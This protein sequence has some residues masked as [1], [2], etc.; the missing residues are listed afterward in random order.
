MSNLS[1]Q[2]EDS[3]RIHFIPSVILLT[4]HLPTPLLSSSGFLYCH[5]PVFYFQSSSDFL[6]CHPP[7]FYFQSSSGSDRRISA[8]SP[9]LSSSGSDRRISANSPI[10]SS[11]ELPPLPVI[12]RSRRRR[13]DLRT[14]V[15]QNK[16]VIPR[17]GLQ[18]ECVKGSSN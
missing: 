15:R 14:L 2:T 8:N 9:F 17:F 13:K 7:V 5:P 6:Y 18:T 12:L 11:S 3:E 16:K 1:S 4:S 10:L